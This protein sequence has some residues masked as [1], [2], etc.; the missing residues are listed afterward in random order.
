VRKALPPVA[1]AHGCIQRGCMRCDMPGVK[2]A[3]ARAWRLRRP[4]C[5]RS[6][7]RCGSPGPPPPGICA[8]R[9]IRHALKRSARGW[10]ACVQLL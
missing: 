5:L 10:R 6:S 8:W 9:G 7:R 3:P 4:C 1:C 2:D